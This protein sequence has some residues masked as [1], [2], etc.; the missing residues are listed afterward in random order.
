MS[1]SASTVRDSKRSSIHLTR[2]RHG[3][4]NEPSTKVLR[5]PQLHFAS[6]SCALVFWQRYCTA[7]QQQASAKLCGVEHRAPPIFSRA[8]ITLAIGPHSSYICCQ[9]RGIFCLCAQQILSLLMGRKH[10][11][12]CEFLCWFAANTPQV[13]WYW[14]FIIQHF[15]SNFTFKIVLCI[16]KGY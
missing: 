9:M 15:R 11:V 4:S 5:R 2:S 16:M 12:F 10:E 6:E 8:T 14:D 3:L 7:L 1:C 13:Y